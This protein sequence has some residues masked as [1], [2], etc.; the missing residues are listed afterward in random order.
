M[1]ITTEDA[2]ESTSYRLLFEYV[3]KEGIEPTI[4]FMKDMNAVLN[5]NNLLV[6]QAVLYGNN[7]LLTL[8][9]RNLDIV[10]YLREH[11]KDLRF[12]DLTRKEVLNT[13]TELSKNIS[14]LGQYLDNAKLL[15]ELK[16][17]KISFFNFPFLKSY[18]FGIWHDYT[19]KIIYIKKYYTDGEMLS[20]DPERMIDKAHNYWEIPFH[21]DTRDETLSF[22]FEANN[23]KNGFQ[24]R[25][26]EITNF[27][28]AGSKLPTEEDIQSYEMP[29]ILI[30][31]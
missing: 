29:K 5:K 15:E 10:K 21:I 24:S 25:K 11:E 14:L 6:K 23:H 18:D 31:K 17:S 2:L 1:P 28:F 20:F 16:V 30:K 9:K 13:L 26:I 7:E 8:V 22:V 27:G 12:F 19:G 3:Q 4:K